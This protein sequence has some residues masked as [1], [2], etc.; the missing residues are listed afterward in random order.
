MSLEQIQGRMEREFA[1]L[2]ADLTRM[3]GT[4]AAIQRDAAWRIA[5]GSRA[6]TPQRSRPVCGGTQ[7]NHGAGCGLAAARAALE[8]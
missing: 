2:R 8:A 4:L 7:P 6:K 5:Q 3:G 1:A